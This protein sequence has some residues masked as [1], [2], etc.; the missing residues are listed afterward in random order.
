[1]VK[2]VL[3][4][5]CGGKNFMT[6]EQLHEF[7]I[8][9]EERNY[10][11]AADMLFS[12]Q[13]T[14]SRHIFA[15]EEEL[16]FLL[17]NRSTKKVELTPEGNRFLVYARN[18]VRIHNA[19]KAAIEEIKIKEN[20]VIKVGYS[21][22]VT[23]YRLTDQLAR[24]MADNPETDVKIIEGSTEELMTAIREG[25]LEIA[26]IQE[27]P[28]EKPRN[29]DFVRYS[30]DTLAVI[31]PADHPLS[32]KSEIDLKELKDENFVFSVL[33]SEPAIVELEACR[34]CGFS[35]KISRH[36]LTGHTLYDWVAESGFIALDWKE[37]A[38]HHLDDRIA[39]VDVVP[40]LYSN[41]LVIY[42][43]ENISPSGRK[44]LEYFEKHSTAKEMIEP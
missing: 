7:V 33:T 44:L 29:I 37:P 9:A 16:G 23:F 15:M 38:R 2:S 14:L 36:G 18:A 25:S 20:G 43:K 35:P 19:C 17:F 27:N 12:T 10:L 22:M 11:V 40:P 34:R 28:F 4:L 24:F 39:I 6:V 32:G 13:A 21:P 8:L 1:M 31:L 30:T 5:F 3:N 42:L 41:S 26:L